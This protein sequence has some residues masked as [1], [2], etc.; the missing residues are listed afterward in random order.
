MNYLEP[1]ICGCGKEFPQRTVWQKHCC[2]K[3]RLREWAKANRPRKTP[4]KVQG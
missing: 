1:K 2:T 4:Q 3:C